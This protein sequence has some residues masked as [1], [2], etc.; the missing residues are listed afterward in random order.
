[1]TIKDSNLALQAKHVYATKFADLYFFDNFLISEIYEGE[2]IGQS[3][4]QEILTLVHKHFGIDKPYGIISHRV[5]SYSVDLYDLLPITSE[6]GPLVANA[7]VAYSN[8][9]LKS[10]ELEKQILKL[11]GEAFSNMEDA[12]SWTRKKINEAHL[13]SF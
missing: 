5:H 2:L 1:M 4:F 11:V 12:I 10:F 9:P 13:L 7:V 6:F 8:M 3:N